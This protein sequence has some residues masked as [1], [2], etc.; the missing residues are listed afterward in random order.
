MKMVHSEKPTAAAAALEENGD[1]KL[2][3]GAK[4]RSGRI[5][6]TK[7]EKGRRNA[8]LPS[9][10]NGGPKSGPKRRR[11]TENLK[12]VDEESVATSDIVNSH[13]ADLTLAAVIKL[14]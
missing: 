1:A 8:N 3:R 7:N 5:V 6:R 11:K 2:A 4:G 9:G 14:A 13:L 12:K 10:S